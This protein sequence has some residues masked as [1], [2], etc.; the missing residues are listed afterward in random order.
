M[1]PCLD[2]WDS[3]V[4]RHRQTRNTFVGFH[5]LSK[6]ALRDKPLEQCAET[7]IPPRKYR[8]PRMKGFAFPFVSSTHRNLPDRFRCALFPTKIQVLLFGICDPLRQ[9]TH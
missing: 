2:A 9:S 3:T 1:D 4:L 5:P 7:I 8:Q 6:I